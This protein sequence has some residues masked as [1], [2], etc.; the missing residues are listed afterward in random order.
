MHD[1]IDIDRRR[2]RERTF[3]SI[4]AGGVILLVLGS[5]GCGG[6]WVLMI[7]NLDDARDLPNGYRLTSI[8]DHGWFVEDGG[9]SVIIPGRPDMD[10]REGVTSIAVVGDIVI[11]RA[12]DAITPPPEDGGP[13]ANHFIL[14]TATG[15]RR[16]N[17]SHEALAQ[18]LA[19]W[20]EGQ[21]S[22]IP[23]LRRPHRL[24]QTAASTPE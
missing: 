4:F 11:G 24:K 19:D 13:Y 14:D 3:L 5:L 23:E 9:G 7:T 8:D 22:N 17:L 6:L 15:R 16:E 18:T 1:S 20:T 21:T 12:V 2:R 10:L